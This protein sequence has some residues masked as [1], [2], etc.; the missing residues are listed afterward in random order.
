MLR[1]VGG[2]FGVCVTVKKLDA[3]LLV[4]V[5]PI[6]EEVIRLVMARPARTG[7]IRK[8]H[9]RNPAR[10]VIRSFESVDLHGF[11]LCAKGFAQCPRSVRHD[12]ADTFAMRHQAEQTFSGV[13]ISPTQLKPT[14]IL[15]R[16]LPQFK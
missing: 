5:S 13:K 6:H 4:C 10:I 1:H 3:N 9:A 15:K 11:V 12:R 14:R 8:R 7:G 16:D 2:F